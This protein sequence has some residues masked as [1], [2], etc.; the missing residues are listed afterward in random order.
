MSWSASFKIGP[1]GRSELRLNGVDTNEHKEQF[2]KAVATALGLLDTGAVGPRSK[3]YLVS[4]T[5]HGN[6]RHLPAAGYANDFVNISIS[7]VAK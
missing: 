2:A 5:G 1:A 7:Q 3:I 6:P 4:L